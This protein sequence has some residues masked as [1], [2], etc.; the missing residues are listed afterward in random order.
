MQLLLENDVAIMFIKC[1]L[2]MVKVW[3]ILS[4]QRNT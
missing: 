3:G 4:D 2:N 1:V